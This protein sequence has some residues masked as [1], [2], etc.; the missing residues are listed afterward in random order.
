M[1]EETSFLNPQNLYT[2]YDYEQNVSYLGRFQI[3]IIKTADLHS[4]KYK[5]RKRH[6]YQKQTF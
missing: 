1:C 6:C 3:K 4:Y 2:M 5:P